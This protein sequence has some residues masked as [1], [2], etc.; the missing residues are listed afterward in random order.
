MN[1]HERIRQSLIAIRDF[2]AEIEVERNGETLIISTETSPAEKP[3]NPGQK[4]VDR[5]LVEK[6]VGRDQHELLDGFEDPLAIRL[7]LQRHEFDIRDAQ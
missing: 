2:G 7:M 4:F 1:D 5:Y 6:K 3:K